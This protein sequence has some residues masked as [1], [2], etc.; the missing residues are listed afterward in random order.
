M[1]KDLW[2]SLTQLLGENLRLLNLNRL[3]GCLTE[4]NLFLD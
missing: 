1:L 3:S 2:L 4:T